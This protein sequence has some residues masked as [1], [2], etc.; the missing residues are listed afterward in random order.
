MIVQ[1]ELLMFRHILGI[2]IP[3]IFSSHLLCI[4]KAVI[5][6]ILRVGTELSLVRVHPII[7]GMRTYYKLRSHFARVITH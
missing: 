2:V 1:H 5:E 4:D 6:T 7:E 3:K